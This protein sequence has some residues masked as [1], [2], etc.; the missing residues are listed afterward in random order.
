MTA[1]ELASLGLALVKVGGKWVLTQI[2]REAAEEALK[3]EADDL[4]R[5]AM[6]PGPCT[7]RKGGINSVDKGRIGEEAAGLDPTK[8][9]RIDSVLD[10]GSKRIPDE[11]DRAN[12]LLKESKNVRHLNWTRQLEDY[13][14]IAER[15]GLTFQ[16]HMPS[17]TTF[18]R[19]AL[20]QVETGRVIHVPYP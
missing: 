14:R 11:I 13:A 15:D 1:A 3:R 19:N 6:R 12:K 7:P 5:Q 18:S 17:S 9:T 2:G 16:I 4:A 20:K 10:P 8:K